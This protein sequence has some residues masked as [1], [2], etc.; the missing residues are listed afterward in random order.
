MVGHIGKEGT[1]MN[2]KLYIENHL[3]AY[4]SPHNKHVNIERSH[5]LRLC[6]QE[7]FNKIFGYDPLTKC[8]LHVVRRTP[9]SK[10]HADINFEGGR[11]KLE[12][13]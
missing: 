6:N 4:N 2:N 7:E 3:Y 1:A 13:R 8:A 9:T 12:S 11:M 5:S 10:Y